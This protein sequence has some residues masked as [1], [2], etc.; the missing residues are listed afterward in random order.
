M[1]HTTHDLEEFW[2]AHP[3]ARWLAPVL[4]VLVTSVLAMLYFLVYPHL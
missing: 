1:A 2:H 4:A 3:G